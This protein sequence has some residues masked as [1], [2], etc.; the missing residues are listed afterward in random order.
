MAILQENVL[1]TMV[2]RAP[3]LHTHAY[4]SPMFDRF[5][6]PIREDQEIEYEFTQDLGYIHQY[7]LMR[8]QMYIAVWGL[9]HFDGKEDAFDHKSAIIIARKDRFCIAGARIVEKRRNELLPME[10]DGFVLQDMLPEFDLK[11]KR[12][13]EAS[14]LAVLPDYQRTEVSM[15]LVRWCLLHAISRGADYMFGIAPYVQARNNQ[16]LAR[17]F[18]LES[19]ILRHIDVPDC[20]GFEGIKMVMVV[21]KLPKKEELTQQKYNALQFLHSVT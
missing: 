16:M 19:Q 21:C 10:H 2:K 13:V 1:E 5:R 12:Y 14:R 8:E 17:H 9:K 3:I 20:P 18:G 4:D 15:N 6:R 7:C 11:N